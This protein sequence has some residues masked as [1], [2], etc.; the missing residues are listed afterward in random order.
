MLRALRPSYAF[1]V[2]AAIWIVGMGWRL[3]PQFADTVRVDDRLMS[4]EDYVQERC[5]E[6]IGDEAVR[7]LRTAGAKAKLL[8]REE[9]VRSAALIAAPLMLYLIY[10]PV[11]FAIELGARLRRRLQAR[12]MPPC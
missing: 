12:A 10:L 1:A 4:A 9:R 11:R 8:I 7:C 3:Y 6:R 5:G 2:L